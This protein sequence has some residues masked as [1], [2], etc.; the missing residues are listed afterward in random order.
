MSLLESYRHDRQVTRL[1]NAWHRLHPYLHVSEAGRDRGSA[2][3]FLEIK[4]EIVSLIPALDGGFASTAL[5]RDAEQAAIRIRHL[6]AQISTLEH[7]D[8]WLERDAHGLAR[9]WHGVFLHLSVLSGASAKRSPLLAL[10]SKTPRA[11]FESSRGGAAHRERSVTARGLMRGAIAL[12]VV[13][14][15]FVV[16]QRLIRSL[17]RDDAHDE[18]IAAPLELR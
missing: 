10:D 8:L 5:D 18:V 2:D 15:T 17:G 9:A 7:V 12:A 11:G 6:V 1:A 13:V 4:R 3:D 14:T 16:A